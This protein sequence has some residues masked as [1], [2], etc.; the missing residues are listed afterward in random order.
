[1]W[2]T[3]WPGPTRPSA[4]SSGCGWARRRRADGCAWRCAPPTYT[5]MP[6]CGPPPTVRRNAPGHA[7]SPSRRRSCGGRWAGGG[8]TPSWPS[9]RAGRPLNCGA[10]WSGSPPWRRCSPRRTGPRPARRRA[11]RAALARRPW[12]GGIRPGPT[13]NWPRSVG[14]SRPS[15]SASHPSIRGWP[16]RCARRRIRRGCAAPWRRARSSSTS[17]PTAGRPGPSWSSRGTCR[18]CA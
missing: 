10:S 3:L 6:R 18:P 1:M 5:S 16:G 2:R 4:S 17:C 9:C 14:R 13:R 8:S 11:S 12:S 15:S 7:S